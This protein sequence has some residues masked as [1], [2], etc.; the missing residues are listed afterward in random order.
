MDVQY[1]C[2][3]FDVSLACLGMETFHVM[4]VVN[5]CP[6]SCIILWMLSVGVFV[7]GSKGRCQSFIHEPTGIYRRLFQPSEKVGRCNFMAADQKVIVNIL[8]I[9]NTRA[10]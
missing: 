1:K 4:S 9:E 3:S 2:I 10:A 7:R 8:H 6:I 5:T